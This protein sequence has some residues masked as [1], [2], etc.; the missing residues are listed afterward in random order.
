MAVPPANAVAIQ[1][2]PRYMITPEGMVWS[3]FTDKYL[4]FNYSQTGYAS[5]ELFNHDGSKRLLVHRL[6]ATAF[7]PNPN[8]F[9]CVN[10]KD[11]NRANNKASNLEWCTYRYNSNY[12]HCQERI[13][14]NRHVSPEKMR[15]FQH[16]GTLSRQRSVIDLDTG[17]VYPSAAAANKAIGK[18]V[19]I[20]SVCKGKRK[21]AAG[22]R[23]AYVNGDDDL[24]QCQS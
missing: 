17:I 12:G 3:N 16:A 4:Q 23:W 10:H 19:R 6:V 20:S 5:V 18:N 2:Y 11:E 14:K 21:T 7:I 8:N 9:P 13:K 15:K 1:G 22:H 24:S